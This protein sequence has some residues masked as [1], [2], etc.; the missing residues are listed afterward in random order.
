MAAIKTKMQTKLFIFI[1]I[2]LILITITYLLTIRLVANYLLKRILDSDKSDE[3]IGFDCI[4][5]LNLPRNGLIA[6]IGP[7][8]LIN[9]EREVHGEMN[10]LSIALCF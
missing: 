4:I 2:L 6:E 8:I 1:I 7:F 5:L 3:C 9:N 10:N